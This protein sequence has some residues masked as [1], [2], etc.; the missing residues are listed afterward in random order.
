MFMLR[1]HFTEHIA[2]VLPVE[3]NVGSTAAHFASHN[4]PSL[5]LSND[6][7]LLNF[8]GRVRF[9][10][11]VFEGHI[12]GSVE[13]LEVFIFDGYLVGI[14]EVEKPSLRGSHF[15]PGEVRLFGESLIKSITF[16]GM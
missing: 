11:M 6:H 10:V 7:S 1:V 14:G 16:I 12:H 3:L 8:V 13:F 9:L 5:G 2:I 15:E 4:C